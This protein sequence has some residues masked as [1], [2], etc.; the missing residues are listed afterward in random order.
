MKKIVI[1]SAAIL[2]VILLSRFY[3]NEKNNRWTCKDGQWIAYGQPS[4]PKPIKSC[5]KKTSLP[6]TKES[7]LA[8]G[9]IWKKIGIDP[10]ESCNKKAADRGNL[11]RDSSECEGRCQVT[12][13]KEELKQGMK[14][15]LFK[16]AKYGQC[17]VWVI[18]LGCR[19]IMKNGEIQVICFD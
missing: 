12:L 5:G 4:Y 9:G 19:G 3:S 8:E 14:G 11:C 17:S 6:K 10:F 7:C 2:A 15:L 13:T 18:E 1:F 16:R